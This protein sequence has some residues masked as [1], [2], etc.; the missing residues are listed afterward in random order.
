VTKSKFLASL[1]PKYGLL[2]TKIE[3]YFH[4]HFRR[5][6]AEKIVSLI[7]YPTIK[8]L[9][10]V[11]IIEVILFWIFPLLNDYLVARVGGIFFYPNLAKADMLSFFSTLWQVQ[12][13]ISAAALPILIFIIE[14]SKDE[15]EAVKRTAEVLVRETYIFPIIVFS[16]IGSAKIGIDTRYYMRESIYCSD[17]LIFFITVFLSC[18]AYYK[19]L[20]LIFSR[21]ELK[22]LS[23][24]LLKEK[25]SKCLDYSVETRVGQN[26][27]LEEIGKTGLT[28]NPFIDQK[29]SDQYIILESGKLGTIEDVNLAKLSKFIRMIRDRFSLSLSENAQ[30]IDSSDLKVPVI[31]LLKLYRE[32]IVESRRGLIAIVRS[33]I[34]EKDFHKEEYEKRLKDIFVVKHY[35]D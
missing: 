1:K 5:S 32:D 7:L 14:L 18:Y 11:I 26:M 9:L 20:L 34:M 35:E 29:E 13:G 15:Q 24:K 21:S 33:S 10:A 22:V 30:H 16:L 23:V 27:L 8:T 12:T 2:S 19:A 28:Y 3:E 6:C 31:H 25:M 4:V 17:S